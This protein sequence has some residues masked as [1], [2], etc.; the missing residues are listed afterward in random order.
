MQVS[1]GLSL[2]FF[3]SSIKP[4]KPKKVKIKKSKRKQKKNEDKELTFIQFI[5]FYPM[6]TFGMLVFFGLAM[7]GFKP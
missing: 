2:E 6:V 7:N 4:S 1:L 5:I 3:F